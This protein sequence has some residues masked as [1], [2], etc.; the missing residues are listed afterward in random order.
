[1]RQNRP[2]WRRGS[3]SGIKEREERSEL[4]L[5]GA[6]EER[7]RDAAQEILK[8]HGINAESGEEER[9]HAIAELL[10]DRNVTAGCGTID[11]DAIFSGAGAQCK[12]VLLRAYT[13]AI[14]ELG[15]SR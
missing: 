3:P 2:T 1:M 4:P 7:A 8:E 11:F 14:R 5:P 6:M 9:R 12:D 15:R 10:T 13:L